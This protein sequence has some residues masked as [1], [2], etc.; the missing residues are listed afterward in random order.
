[1][2]ST[3]IFELNI[4]YN[5]EMMTHSTPYK[6]IWKI[7]VIEVCD[8]KDTQQNSYSISHLLGTVTTL[9]LEGDCVVTADNCR[10]SSEHTAIGSSVTA[11]LESQ[12]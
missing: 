4:A 8:D 12:F 9:W 2:F 1:M 6:S 7:S 10:Q 11:V 5:S 3:S